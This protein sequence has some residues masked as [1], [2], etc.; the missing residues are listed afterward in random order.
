MSIPG[1]VAYDSLKGQADD[2]RAVVELKLEKVF[3][4]SLSN[5]LTGRHLSNGIDVGAC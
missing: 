5:Y 2:N 1:I 3:A 4:N